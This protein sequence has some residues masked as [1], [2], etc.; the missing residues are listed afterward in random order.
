MI[1]NPTISKVGTEVLFRMHQFHH[2]SA[3]REKNVITLYKALRRGNDPAALDRLFGQIVS[4]LKK[5]QSIV[6]INVGNKIIRESID[7]DYASS[8]RKTFGTH[9]IDFLCSRE[10]LNKIS[11]QASKKV[12]A[13]EGIKPFGETE[14]R[15]YEPGSEY[16][17]L[18]DD[19]CYI[20]LRVEQS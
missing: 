12:K 7:L 10:T 1:E 6:L 15:F 18:K 4:D 2:R 19:T 13:Y 8:K 3:P 14:T 11:R 9:A 17:I 16:T 20:A 5:G